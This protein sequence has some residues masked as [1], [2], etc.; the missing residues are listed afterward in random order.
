MQKEANVHAKFY[1]DRVGEKEVELDA[2]LSD[3]GT[4]CVCISEDANLEMSPIAAK[5][6]IAQLNNANKE[7]ASELLSSEEIEK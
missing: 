4:I 3:R 7:F 2:Y 5:R 1:H 6:L